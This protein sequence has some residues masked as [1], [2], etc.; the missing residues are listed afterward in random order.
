[1]VTSRQ[2][3]LTKNKYVCIL[4]RNLQKIWNDKQVTVPLP[5]ELQAG[6]LDRNSNMQEVT[7]LRSLKMTGWNQASTLA[8]LRH[9]ILFQNFL[10]ASKR[11]YNSLYSCSSLVVSVTVLIHL[12]Y[13]L[14]WHSL[15]VNK[16]VTLL[17]SRSDSGS[18]SS[19]SALCFRISRRWSGM[20]SES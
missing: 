7:M 13:Q 14:Q 9:L 19:S 2:Y 4:V 8:R 1:M 5:C 15:S 6:G 18:S 10:I 20:M 11:P 16:T 17:S 3:I 12:E